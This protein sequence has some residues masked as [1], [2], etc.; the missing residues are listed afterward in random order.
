MV[1]AWFAIALTT[2]GGLMHRTSSCTLVFV[3]TLYTE[4]LP[5][6]YR[7]PTEHLP[8]TYR[9]PT[10]HLPSSY[11][12]P[13]TGGAALGESDTLNTLSSPCEFSLWVRYMS[14]NCV[15]THVQISEA[16]PNTNTGACF[17]C[18]DTKAPRATCACTN[19]FIHPECLSQT[20]QKTNNPRCTVCLEPY[21]NVEVREKIVR[22]WHYDWIVVTIICSLTIAI[23]FIS[24]ALLIGAHQHTVTR[25]CAFSFSAVG[26]LSSLYAVHIVKR[27]LRQNIGCCVERSRVTGIVVVT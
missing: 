1:V 20:V 27:A 9:A 14:I 26:V 15:P 25:M 16:T 22:R 4:H 23:L 24:A 17:I 6:T 8:S 5:S 11:R 13:S 18:F 12:A 19:M 10:E 2:L 21:A 7:A 3:C